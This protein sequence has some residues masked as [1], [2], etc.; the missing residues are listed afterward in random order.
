[1]SYLASLVR[2]ATPSSSVDASP[3]A[4]PEPLLEAVGEVDAAVAT[5]A[6]QVAA[7]SFA[8]DTQPV[9]VGVTVR[10]GK[11]ATPASA[12]M[13][14]ID[15][16]PEEAQ[17]P[18]PVPDATRPRNE[19]PLAA[20]PVLPRR[21]VAPDATVAPRLERRPARQDA[22]PTGN[23][24]R[25]AIA[26][27]VA[28]DGVAEHQPSASPSRKTRNADAGERVVSVRLPEDITTRDA[29]GDAASVTA[30]APQR[31]A[32]SN[33]HVQIGSIELTV[34][35]PAA[36]PPSMSTP[37]IATGAAPVPGTIPAQPRPRDDFRFSASRHY[38]RRG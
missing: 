35:T 15:P 8:V 9:P 11:A 5:E 25:V 28:P 16:R 12:R 13:R 10:E 17:T 14:S 18:S 1:M 38:L 20:E 30:G 32:A 26:M 36:S 33:W 31:P 34:K 29:R 37:G 22:P 3:A 24:A 7:H 27:P 4:G 23:T 21:D 19:S 6:T 2:P